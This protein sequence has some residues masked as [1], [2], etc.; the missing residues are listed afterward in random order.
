L[1]WTSLP[2]PIRW[3][4]LLSTAGRIQRSPVDDD[5]DSL[6][7]GRVVVV[8]GALEPERVLVAGAAAIVNRETERPSCALG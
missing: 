5:R 2:K 4:I 6:A 1:N 8:T 3:M 7:R